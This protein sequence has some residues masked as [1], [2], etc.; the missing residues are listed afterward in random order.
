MIEEAMKIIAS[1]AID[2]P[3]IAAA[4]EA[5]AKAL[6]AF[7]CSEKTAVSVEGKGDLFELVAGVLKQAQE[8]CP[9]H[10]ADFKRLQE[11]LDDAGDVKCGGS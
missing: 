3:K 2:C 5:N 11:L 1:I 8:D 10:D 6:D 7:R 4:L 9:D